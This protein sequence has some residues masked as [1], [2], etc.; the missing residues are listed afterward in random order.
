LTVRN[1]VTGKRGVAVA[2]LSREGVRRNGIL[3]GVWE[4]IGK[5]CHGRVTAGAR[6]GTKW[7]PDCMPWVTTGGCR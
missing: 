4:G 3:G 5:G 7:L 6:E 2:Q 1:F